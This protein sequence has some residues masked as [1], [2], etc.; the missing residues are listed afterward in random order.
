[1]FDYHT[2]FPFSFCFLLFLSIVPTSDLQ[3]KQFDNKRSRSMIELIEVVE[4]LLV[5]T[6]VSFSSDVSDRAQV[7]ASSESNGRNLLLH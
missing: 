4:M 2:N 1:M 5:I 3:N 7:I 6:E